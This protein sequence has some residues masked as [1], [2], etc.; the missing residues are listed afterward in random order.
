MINNAIVSEGIEYILQHLYENI[1]LDDVA[2][3]C[4][5]SVSRFSVIFKEQTGESVYSFVKRLKMEQSA[6]Q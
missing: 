1:T 3:H 6:F 5:M 2:R 4:C